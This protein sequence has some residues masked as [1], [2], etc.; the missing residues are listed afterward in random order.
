MVLET[1]KKVTYQINIK[2]LIMRKLVVG[3]ADGTVLCD[4][5]PI[6]EAKDMRVTLFTATEGS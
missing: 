1:A 4:G 5:E 2:R 3:I 6:F